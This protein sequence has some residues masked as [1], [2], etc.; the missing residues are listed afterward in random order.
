MAN[1]D[2][3][4]VTDKTGRF[5]RVLDSSVQG[6]KIMTIKPT[7]TPKPKVSMQRMVQVLITA[8]SEPNSKSE[9]AVVKATKEKRTVTIAKNASLIQKE[10]SQQIAPARL[11]L[12]T[13]SVKSTYDVRAS[14]GNPSRTQGT[15]LFLPEKFRNIL[16]RDLKTLVDKSRVPGLSKSLTVAKKHLIV[17]CTNSLKESATLQ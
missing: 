10:S 15:L 5:E 17:R 4:L 9:R 11:S 8:S 12:K 6:R 13:K 14:K 1:G 3:Q 16:Q 2:S 7:P